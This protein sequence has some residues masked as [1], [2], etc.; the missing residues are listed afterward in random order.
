MA[1]Q[2]GTVLGTM[3]G[4]RAVVRCPEAPDIGDAVADGSGRRIGRVSRV[5]G[6]VDKPYASVNL[7]EGAKVRKDTALYT[8]GGRKNGNRQKRRG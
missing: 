8:V 7:D 4:S 6:P 1:K 2:L 3:N 5:F